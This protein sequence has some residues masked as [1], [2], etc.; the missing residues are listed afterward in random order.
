[1]AVIVRESAPPVR[2]K[3]TNTFEDAFLHGSSFPPLASREV[4]RGPEM[5]ALGGEERTKGEVVQGAS[6]LDRGRISSFPALHASTCFHRRVTHPTALR[7]VQ[8]RSMVRRDG[9][10]SQGPRDESLRARKAAR[11]VAF[12]GHRRASPPLDDVE[13]SPARRLHPG[14]GREKRSCV[15][16]SY[17]SKYQC[18]LLMRV[19]S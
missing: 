14:E 13:T 15:P 3:R 17:E 8:A 16:S 18:A 1:M 4:R 11:R 12:H 5:G 9:G 7:V 19:F 6:R 2:T 10:P